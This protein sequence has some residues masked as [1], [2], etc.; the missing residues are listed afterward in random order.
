MVELQ[1][2]LQNRNCFDFKITIRTIIGMKIVNNDKK[3][4][5]VVLRLYN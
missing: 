1:K 5:Y 3:N 2:N 4:E